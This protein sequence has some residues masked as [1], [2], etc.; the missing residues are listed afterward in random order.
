MLSVPIEIRFADGQ[1]P[2]HDKVEEYEVV[3]L[4]FLCLQQS[5]A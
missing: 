3:R 2:N 5:A 4:F 1:I